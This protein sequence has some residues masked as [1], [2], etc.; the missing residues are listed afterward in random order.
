MTHTQESKRK[1]SGHLDLIVGY[2]LGF[3]VW[4]LEFQKPWFPNGVA[5]EEG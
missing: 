5:I 2:Y 1:P 4:D 3:G